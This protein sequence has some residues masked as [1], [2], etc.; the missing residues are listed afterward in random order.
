M[1]FDEYAHEY[2]QLLDKSVRL[3]GEGADYFADYKVGVLQRMG[4]PEPGSRVLDFGCGI[5]MLTGRLA[6]AWPGCRIEGYDVSAESI[7]RAANASSGLDNVAFHTNLDDDTEGYDLIVSANVFHHIEPP[8]RQAAARWI[9]D[10]LKPGGRCVIFEHNPLNPL[11]RYSVKICP[12]DKG[13]V[14]LPR[15]ETKSLLQSAGLTISRSN[16]IVFFPAF[17]RSLRGA[18]PYL[19]GCPLGAQYFVQADAPGPP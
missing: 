11:T 3:T 13:V 17:L 18:E 5:G 16:Y 1:C 15:L 7:R 9:A 2:R 6:T 8:D 10:R 12:F 19:G 4:Q 14:L